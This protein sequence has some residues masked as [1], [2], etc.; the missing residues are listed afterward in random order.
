MA[1]DEALLI[2]ALAK[3]PTK[4]MVVSKYAEKFNFSKNEEINQIAQ[5]V[6]ENNDKYLELLIISQTPLVI[7][8]DIKI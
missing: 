4:G 7:E 1:T 8:K 2:A 6:K 5:N 3:H